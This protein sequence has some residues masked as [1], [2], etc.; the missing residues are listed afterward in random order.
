M[1]IVRFVKVS[2]L[3]AAVMFVLSSSGWRVTWR[4]WPVAEPQTVDVSC[5]ARLINLSE[6]RWQAVCT[7]QDVIT[8]SVS[9]A[10]SLH[11]IY[12]S[13]EAFCQVK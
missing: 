9:K 6:T 1:I 2:E 4:H 13:C 7:L 12:C 5:N 3:S 10:L 8:V 11:L